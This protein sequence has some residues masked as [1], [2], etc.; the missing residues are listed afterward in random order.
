VP[1]TYSIVRRS[2]T[3]RR[4]REIHF[5]QKFSLANPGSG[6]EP[7]HTSQ[8]HPFIGCGPERRWRRDAN[9]RTY[10][11]TQAQGRPS[12][13]RCGQEFDDK[14]P[15]AGVSWC[16]TEARPSEMSTSR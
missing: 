1:S 4:V 11:G 13:W 5:E 7:G 14:D 6:R 16:T 2:Q 3:G 15:R 10:V 8:F 9:P 12:G